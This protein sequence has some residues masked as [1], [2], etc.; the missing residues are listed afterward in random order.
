[1]HDVLRWRGLGSASRRLASVFLIAVLC[2]CPSTKRR[3]L[4]AP[5][6]S[7]EADDAA[8]AALE[9]EIFGQKPVGLTQDGNCSHRILIQWRA[10]MDERVYS[11]PIILDIGGDGVKD[12]EKH[13]LKS[14]SV[15]VS[16]FRRHIY[17]LDGVYGEHAG[18]FPFTFPDSAFYASPIVY[19]INEDGEEDIGLTTFNGE[20]I[21]VDAG[22]MPIFG[23]SIKLPHMRVRKDWLSGLGQG[24]DEIL[25]GE[26]QYEIER[27]GPHQNDPRVWKG[28]NS[29]QN[30]AQKYHEKVWQAA[31]D[32]PPSAGGV[33]LAVG[34][35]RR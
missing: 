1:M 26:T 9:G 10:E 12:G 20:L 32:T 29:V 13:H 35:R 25:T 34:R 16:T 19:D 8:A 15:V 6:K 3:V 7:A 11:T 21:W 4:A 14:N 23:K 31:M 17:V 24:A 22:G 27:R 18:G 28:R 33:P 5:S 30:S 2:L